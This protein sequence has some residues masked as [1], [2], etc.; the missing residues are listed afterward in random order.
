MRGPLEGIEGVLVRDTTGDRLMVSIELLN[1]GACLHI[2]Q[3]DV[4]PV[5]Q[6][7]KNSVASL[8]GSPTK[9]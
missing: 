1:Q 4:C 3:E 5:E 9:Q 7:E 2:N 6:A 8:W